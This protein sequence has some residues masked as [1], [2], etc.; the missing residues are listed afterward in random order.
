MSKTF[1]IYPQ[2]N[3]RNLVYIDIIFTVGYP[4]S[5][6]C[7]KMLKTCFKV[8]RALAEQIIYSVPARHLKTFFWRPLCAF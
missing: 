5:Y 3:I 7:A 4:K 8:P 2:K 1:I 6:I